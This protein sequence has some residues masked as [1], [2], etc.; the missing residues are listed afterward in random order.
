MTSDNTVIHL[1]DR[2]FIHEGAIRRLT[3]LSLILLSIPFFMQA[4]TIRG[5]V[6]SADT[7][8]PLPGAN[9]FVPTT[10][11]GCIADATGRFQLALPP[12]TYTVRVTMI[13]YD[14]YE[15]ILVVASDTS[16]IDFNPM[17]KERPLSVPEV[18]IKGRRDRE[19]ESSSRLA[20]KQ[21][22]SIISVVGAQTI[23]R[24][25]DRTV[26][27]VLSRVPGLSVSRDRNG[28]GQYVVMRGH[29]QMDINT[30]ALFVSYQPLLQRLVRTRW[31][32]RLPSS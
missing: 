27:D 19:L 6:R 1:R 21:A 11:L 16:L 23:E 18:V 10:S 25:T 24:S 4:G 26:A 31:K 15:T 29:D 8:E 3:W 30:S 32:Q 14:H 2:F 5:I 28:E 7:R 13:G 22:S 20:E 12:G 9:V 17:L